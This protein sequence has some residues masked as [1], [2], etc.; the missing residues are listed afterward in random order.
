MKTTS[1]TELK[2][3]LSALLKQVVAGEPLLV[4]DRNRPVAVFQ[5]LAGSA[6]G[7]HRLAGLIA[8]GVV[9]PASAGALDV[10]AFLAEPKAHCAEPLSSAIAEDRDGR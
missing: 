3:S 4:T 9:A 6:A 1:V 8:S 2:N 10:E 5:P 7:D